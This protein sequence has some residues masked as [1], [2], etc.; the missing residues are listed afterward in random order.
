MPT[1]G[2]SLPDSSYN[3]APFSLWAWCF[4]NTKILSDGFCL[5]LN[6][7]QFVIVQFFTEIPVCALT[8]VTALSEPSLV[9]TIS[10]IT[11]LEYNKRFKPD[12]DTAWFCLCFCDFLLFCFSETASHIVALAGLELAT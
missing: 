1:S 8:L 9:F 7:S 10:A 5:N 3:T 11:E 4:T 6:L 12:L 2:W